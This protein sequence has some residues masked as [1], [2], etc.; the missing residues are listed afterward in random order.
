MT[1]AN[2]DYLSVLAL[3]FAVPAKTNPEDCNVRAYGVLSVDGVDPQFAWVALVCHFGQS[4]NH[5]AVGVI[6]WLDR[7]RIPSKCL[8]VHPV[9]HDTRAGILHLKTKDFESQ[10]LGLLFYAVLC[11]TSGIQSPTILKQNIHVHK[12]SNTDLP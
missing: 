4:D 3:V 2:S 5:R 9:V 12:L 10:T 1:I 11:H 7:P 6:Y 8:N